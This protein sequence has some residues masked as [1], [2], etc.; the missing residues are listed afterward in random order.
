MASEAEEQDAIDFV[1][2]KLS[3]ATSELEY[4][5]KSKGGNLIL[6]PAQKL[7]LSRIVNELNEFKIG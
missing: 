7:K 4:V 2:S 1:E 5:L 6:T 3:S